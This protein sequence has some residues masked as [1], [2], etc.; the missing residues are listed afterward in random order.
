M[1]LS[2]KAIGQNINL[3]VLGGKW[4]LDNIQEDSY[5]EGIWIMLLTAVV[6]IFQTCP[7]FDGSF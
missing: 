5:N 1:N 6:N 7:H 2:K 3:L 4:Q